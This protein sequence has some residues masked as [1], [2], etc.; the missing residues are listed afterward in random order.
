[1]NRTSFLPGKKVGLQTLDQWIRMDAKMF[2]QCHTKDPEWVQSLQQHLHSGEA[3]PFLTCLDETG[4]MHD[5]RRV[6]HL[7]LAAIAFKEMHHWISIEESVRE[8]SALAVRL[9]CQTLQVVKELAPDVPRFQGDPIKFF[10][11]GMGKLGSGELNPGSDIDLCFFYETDSCDE[12][13]ATP[14]EYFSQ[15]VR[16]FTRILS[17]NT[18]DGFCYRIDHRLRPYG[19]KGSLVYS[20]DQAIQYFET[21]GRLWERLAWLRANVVAGDEQ[22]GHAFLKSLRPFVFRKQVDPSIAGQVYELLKQSRKTI[23]NKRNIKLGYGGIRAVEF[24]VQSLQLIWGGQFPPLQ[25]RSTVQALGTMLSL[26]LISF[27]E[28]DGLM[29]A[30][31]MLRAL[32][33]RIQYWTGIQTHDLPNDKD[34][35]L[36]WVQSVGGEGALYFKN[37]EKCREEVEQHFASLL[38]EGSPVVDPALLILAI[39]KK[40]MAALGWEKKHTSELDEDM[41]CSYFQK[42]ARMS[43]G[44]F[45]HPTLGWQIL[46]EIKDCSDPVSAAQ[47]LTD[48]FLRTK[49][50]GSY[51]K[52]LAESERWRG[53]LLGLLGSSGALSRALLSRPE[54]INWVFSDEVVRKEFIEDGHQH[55]KSHS[56]DD[57]EGFVDALRSVQVE[58]QL[59]IGLGFMSAGLDLQ[60]TM[61]CHS[62]LAEAQIQA[63]QNF[64]DVGQS[65]EVV[66]LGKLAGKELGYASDLDVLFLGEQEQNV[67]AQRLVRLLCSP[68]VEGNGYEVDTRLR[69]RGEQGPLVTSKTQWLDYLNKQAAE[70]EVIASLRARGS[71]DGLLRDVESAVWDRASFDWSQPYA[72]RNRLELELGQESQDEHDIKYGFGGLIEIEFITY[73][74]AY[75]HKKS[76]S[77]NTAS[78]IQQLKE[79]GIIGTEVQQILTAS[80]MTLRMIEQWLKITSDKR[81][82]RVIWNSPVMFKVARSMMRHGWLETGSVQELRLRYEDIRQTIRS[83]YLTYA[84]EVS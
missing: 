61:E 72:I 48:F 17:E 52:M 36:E 22:L 3:I 35:V 74:L 28:H 73:W 38:A 30:W 50:S 47:H 65:L 13:Q 11:V 59:R 79:L 40:D 37:F 4:A 54:R 66:R 24:A 21:T 57:M 19:Q 51:Q 29:S 83:L 78:A 23:D 6:Y 41:L 32:E 25:T 84:R 33:H 9:I 27:R 76:V 10:C 77:P 7:S 45:S 18:E 71:H 39:E 34:V 43:G 75:R 82:T 5:L 14:Q 58:F 12:G 49:H 16:T 69:P 67:S 53:R 81:S 15:V 26:G 42:M 46:Q 70:W 2:L 68:S 44:P 31:K 63:I 8:I 60:D 62:S 20:V 1:M 55:L 64:L 56:K 80:Y